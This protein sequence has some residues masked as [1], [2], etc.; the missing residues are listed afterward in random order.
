MAEYQ[1]YYRARLRRYDNN[2]LYPATAA[3][4]REMCAAVEASTSVEDMQQRVVGAG[5]NIATGRALL[6]DQATA[7]AALFAETS[8]TVR[9]QGP[10]AV[11]AGVDA[12][13]D[14]AALA[15]LGSTAELDAQRAVTADELTRLWTTSLAAL[16]NVEVWQNAVVLD[17]W[18]AELAG[19]VADTSASQRQVWAQL[20]T[21][22]QQQAPGWRF[23]EA[24]AREDRH[25]RLVPMPD[26]TLD[27]RLAQHRSIVRGEG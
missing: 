21:D 18:R 7:R 1:A 12:V 6:R 15:S 25:R 11:L 16:E 3:A 10:A 19:Y 2:P 22:A 4:E 20:T 26:A 5:L 17:Q 9:A 14:A 27:R 23:D 13:T 8:E 24:R